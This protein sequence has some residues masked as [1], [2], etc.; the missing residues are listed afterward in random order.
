MGAWVPGGPLTP[1]SWGYLCFR[2]WKTEPLGL[3]LEL[4]GSHPPR[5]VE[6]VGTFSLQLEAWSVSIFISHFLL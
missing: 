5:K 4:A 3:E 2:V 1:G 6:V